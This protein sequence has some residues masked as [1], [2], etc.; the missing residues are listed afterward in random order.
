MDNE[1]T[2]SLLVRGI[3]TGLFLAAGI[4]ALIM[5]WRLYS[6]GT[7]MAQDGT[8]VEAER[9]KV[10][11]KASLQ[12]VGS[13]VMATSIGWGALAYLSLPKPKVEQG[14]TGFSMSTN[15]PATKWSMSTNR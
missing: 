3:L 10:K 4:M 5:G 12:T 13:V 7:G 8:T 14:S 6:K 11:G 2:Q 1:F 9:G 15:Q